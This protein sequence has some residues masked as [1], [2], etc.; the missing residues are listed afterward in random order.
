VRLEGL[1]RTDF[2]TVEARQHGLAQNE[3]WRVNIH[4]ENTNDGDADRYEQAMG[5]YRWSRGSR[6]ADEV[7]RRCPPEARRRGA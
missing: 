2:L 4:G 5:V 1:N 3:D 6:A 7:R